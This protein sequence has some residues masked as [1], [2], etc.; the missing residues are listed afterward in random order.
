MEKRKFVAQHA[1]TLLSRGRVGSPGYISV[2]AFHRIPEEVHS[3]Q[4]RSEPSRVIQ[5]AE[6]L[7]TFGKKGT[8]CDYS[9]L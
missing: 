9:A 1:T 2:T 4:P 5:K 7:Y 8:Q 3:N 6:V